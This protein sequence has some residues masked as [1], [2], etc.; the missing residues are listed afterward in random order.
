LGLL[1][2]FGTPLANATIGDADVVVVVGSRL[3]PSDTA[4]HSDELID[5]ARQAIVQV[6]V[7]AKNA[8]VGLPADLN[9]VGDAKVALP[10]LLDE[11]GPAPSERLTQTRVALAQR[12]AE[13]GHFDFPEMSSSARPILPQRLVRELQTALD[14]DAI[15]CC[16]AGENRLFM[17]HYFQTKA[18]GGYIQ[19]SGVGAMGYAVPAALAARLAEPGRQVVAVCGDGGFAIALNSLMT[20]R[21]EE[22]PIVVVVMNNQALGWVRHGLSG[23]P[24]ACDFADF[25]YAAVAR[26]LGCEGIHVADPNDLAPALHK[27]LESGR[28]TVVDVRTS[29]DETF[30][31]VTSPIVARALRSPARS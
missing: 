11:L 17:M 15:V 27:A 30:E 25:D 12:R 6:D 7:E 13:L 14:D 2:N 1:G 22:L 16:D 20:S 23:N 24:I 21:E 5:P 31:K 19:S 9:V 3:S 8:N 26:S 10:R 18:S 4:F 29:L 28:T